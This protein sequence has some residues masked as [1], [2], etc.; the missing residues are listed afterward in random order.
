MR[1][2]SAPS[3][4]DAIVVDETGLLFY[5][6]LGYRHK[7]GIVCQKIGPKKNASW[8]ANMHFSFL[9][10]TATSVY[11][12]SFPRLRDLNPILLVSLLT[13]LVYIFGFVI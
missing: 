6:C 2:T 10:N 8:A 12:P 3:F 7:C 9:Q 13:E 1:D 11:S 4:I 5:Q